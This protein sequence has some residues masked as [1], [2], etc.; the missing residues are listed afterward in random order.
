MTSVARKR[1]ETRRLLRSVLLPNKKGLL[2]TDLEKEFRG[3][4]GTYVPYRALGYSS[5]MSLLMDMSD[6]AT[7]EKLPSGH[8]LVMATPDHSTQHIADMVSC[9]KDN[10]EG[11]NQNTGRVL[12]GQ[13]RLA[14]AI[15]DFP[16]HQIIPADRTVSALMKERLGM[17]L[18]Q[19][20]CGLLYSQLSASYRQLHGEELDP[21]SSGQTSGLELCCQLPDVVQIQQVEGGRDW[22]LLPVRS[23]QSQSADLTDRSSIS[24]L[25]D[26]LE[27]QQLPHN[28]CVGDYVEVAVTAVRSTSKLYIQLRNMQDMLGELTEAIGNEIKVGVEG[29]LRPM[30]VRVG[31][32]VAALINGHWYRV[33][34][35]RMKE[36]SKVKIFL[37][38]YGIIL[39][40]QV[41]SLRYLSEQ[42]S[43]VPAQAIPV[44]LALPTSLAKWPHDTGAKLKQVLI[45]NQE[46][47]GVIMAKLE[48]LQDQQSRM[49][50]WLVDSK[51]VIINKVLGNESN[52]LTDTGTRQQQL[53]NRLT[54][55]SKLVREKLKKAISNT[56]MVDRLECLVSR[57]E[58]ELIPESVSRVFR[59]E[60]G[61]CIMHIMQW[62][63]G[64]W[65]ASKEIASLVQD[66]RG[67]DLLDKMILSKNM[68]LEKVVLNRDKD[69]ELWEEID[70]LK[71]FNEV[72]DESSFYL[73][74]DVPSIV[75][76]FARLET[77]GGVVERVEEIVKSCNSMLLETER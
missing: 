34:V 60:V 66:W 74:G 31:M 63:G 23:Q 46:E 3:M 16:Q 6:V 72:T 33:I 12:A 24:Q 19:F 71:V 50:V 14:K 76:T 37:N 77:R 55:V 53:L 2:L 1:E 17:L 49:A 65:C 45:D 70:S 61:E 59:T 48:R 22:L 40:V 18:S 47:G 44:T 54:N 10:M 25:S 28:V 73:L 5:L 7:M 4:T 30:E 58:A 20:P 29:E 8:Q 11:Y 38:D 42:L 51:G 36:M 67:W 52:T 62:Q 69:A 68:N 57:L 43:Q 27:V 75:R 26:R 64:Y 13:S 56:A 21:L 35:L 9:Q 32:V 15:H 41:S 39:T